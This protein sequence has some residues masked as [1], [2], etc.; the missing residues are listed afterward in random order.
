MNKI[1]DKIIIS[2]IIEVETGLHIGGNESFSA[3]GEADSVIIK[4][5]ISE[6]PFIPGSS[7][8]GKIRSLLARNLNDD[9]VEP[10]KDSEVITRLFGASDPMIYGKL[11]FRDC[12]WSDTSEINK[13]TDEH[14]ITEIKPENTINRISAVA[15][16]R[17]IER[18]PKGNCFNFELVYNIFDTSELEE[19]FEN[20]CLG[21]K[22]LEWDYLGGN[23]TRGYGKVKI[24]ELE[25]TSLSGQEYK[26]VTEIL[27]NRE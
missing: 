17:F 18:V 23:G 3:I 7:L 4:D 1:K 8:K 24:D 22:L 16:P 21:L 10:N 26:S 27:E 19:D 15:K 6:K 5:P 9:I 12:F 20:I 14:T 2:G 13:F 11:I 25:I